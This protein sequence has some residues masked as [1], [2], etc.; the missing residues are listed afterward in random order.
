MDELRA[1]ARLLLAAV[2]SNDLPECLALQIAKEL[3]GATHLLM[4][5]RHAMWMDRSLKEVTQ[6]RWERRTLLVE[7]V[8]DKLR[9]DVAGDAA[10]SAQVALLSADMSLRGVAAAVEELHQHCRPE[11]RLLLRECFVLDMCSVAPQP[12]TTSSC[13]QCLRAL[14]GADVLKSAL[15]HCVRCLQDGRGALCTDPKFSEL[16]EEGARVLRF[17]KSK[18]SGKRKKKAQFQPP[19]RM[20]LEPMYALHLSFESQGEEP[21]EA[22]YGT[23]F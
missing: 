9:E 5:A 10:L 1:S 4:N 2:E 11:A 13:E 21:D 7:H 15:Q 14:V 23:A 12:L 19:L 17:V 22:L 3:R 6:G 20:D 18:A 16:Y 8:A